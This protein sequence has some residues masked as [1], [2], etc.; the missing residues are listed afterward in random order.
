[1]S[2]SPT[3]NDPHA[4]SESLTI[5][6]LAE[7]FA[8]QNTGD[9]DLEEVQVRAQEI[10]KESRGSGGSKHFDSVGADEMGKLTFAIGLPAPRIIISLMIEASSATP[11]RKKTWN[12][13]LEEAC[14]GIKETGCIKIDFHD[15]IN[16]KKN[17]AYL[18]LEEC[19]KNHDMG[20]QLD[21]IYTRI[22]P[23][24]KEDVVGHIS[25]LIHLGQKVY[26][27]VAS[28][29]STV[30]SEIVEETAPSSPDG[31][32]FDPNALHVDPANTTLHIK[33]P[34]ELRRVGLYVHIAS[35][36]E[37]LQAGAESDDRL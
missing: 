12:R 11:S 16:N 34:H 21:K 36:D 18:V 35:E 26:H 4:D 5:A 29:M 30:L 24:K 27:Q 23:E 37:I 9:V 33:S 8:G 14:G 13:R 6:K 7:A 1:M 17:T 2:N 28:K 22:Q 20:A 31:G 25:M 32:P 3:N 19:G 15:T 10:I